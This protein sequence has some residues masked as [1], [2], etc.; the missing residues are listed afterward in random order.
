MQQPG[1]D[2]EICCCGA[3]RVDAVYSRLL[4]PCSS[5]VLTA[6]VLQLCRSH[7]QRPHSLYCI[8]LN[9][10]SPQITT[11]LTP[12]RPNRLYPP[13]RSACLV[14]AVLRSK[15]KKS[16]S[17]RDAHKSDYFPNHATLRFSAHVMATSATCWFNIPSPVAVDV[18]QS[19]YNSFKLR[20]SFVMFCL[21]FCFAY[22]HLDHDITFVSSI[23]IEYTGSRH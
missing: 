3:G 20:L 10:N 23:C 13:A 14:W 19:R 2:G 5:P 22:I 9:P 8:L 11:D 16:V 4:K 1:S 12:S 21:L 6:P 18:S 7:L 17:V 15:T